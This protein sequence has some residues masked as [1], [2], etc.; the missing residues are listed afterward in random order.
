MFYRGTKGPI[1]VHSG[2]AELTIL[3]NNPIRHMY[4]TA[5]TEDF[6]ILYHN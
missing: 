4:I 1:N 5:Q 3:L 6:V 2:I